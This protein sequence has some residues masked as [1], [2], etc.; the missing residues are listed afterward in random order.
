MSRVLLVEDPD[1]PISDGTFIPVSEMS[2]C[3]RKGALRN[4]PMF[5][6]HEPPARETSVGSVAWPRCGKYTLD[7]VGADQLNRYITP[8]RMLDPNSDGDMLQSLEVVFFQCIRGDGDFTGDTSRTDWVSSAHF[9]VGIHGTSRKLN[10]GKVYP[11]LWLD[12]FPLLGL[13][14]VRVSI[15][16]TVAVLVTEGSTSSGFVPVWVVG[17][18][19]PASSNGDML[20]ISPR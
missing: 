18:H 17:V 16:G 12:E 1:R 11:S 5:D 13:H 7:S 15:E 2:A 20:D 4:A 6:A 19:G 8:L 14:D 10:S 3:I 9:E